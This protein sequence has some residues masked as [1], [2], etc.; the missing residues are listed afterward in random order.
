MSRREQRAVEQARLEEEA[1]R[2]AERARLA[3]EE[4]ERKAAEIRAR[5][6]QLRREQQES[7][8]R[9]KFDMALEAEPSEEVAVEQVVVEVERIEPARRPLRDQFPAAATKARVTPSSK[10]PVVGGGFGSPKYLAGGAIAIVAVA[11]VAF[12]LVHRGGTGKAPEYTARENQAAQSAAPRQAQPQASS[13]QTHAAST[14][15]QSQSATA[16]ESGPKPD[17]P[18][19]KT[20]AGEKKEASDAKNLTRSSADLSASTPAVGSAT[21]GKPNAADTGAAPVRISQGVSE[22]WL[23]HKV[24]PT[25]PPLARQARVQGQ[26]VLDVV[27]A[28]NGSIKS[29]AT[30]SGHPMLIPAAIDAVKQWQYQPYKV[31]GKPVEVATRVFVNFS[32]TN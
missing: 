8:E 24:K 22:G 3:Q 16:P 30:E 29:I 28:K 19:E 31:S 15:P 12:V 6:E 11:V 4:Q 25:Y 10:P 5:Q 26:V 1:R 21:G 14:S 7:V 27:I 9:A 32:L 18:K 20:S 13:E 2:A 17:Q 23:I